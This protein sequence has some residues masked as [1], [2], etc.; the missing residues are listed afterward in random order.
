[1]CPSLMAV[2]SWTGLNSGG[3]QL[4]FF[5]PSWIYAEFNWNSQPSWGLQITIARASWSPLDYPYRNRTSHGAEFRWTNIEYYCQKYIL[6]FEFSPEYKPQKVVFA[7]RVIVGGT[8]VIY[9]PELML[10][11][12]EFR[13]IY[14]DSNGILSPYGD[15]R[16]QLSE[17]DSVWA[18]LRVME[19]DSWGEIPVNSHW[20][21]PKLDIQF[22]FSAE[23]EP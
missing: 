8:I 6:T 20:I 15:L 13:W 22:E 23:F 9:R 19:L 18:S 16:Q 14:S 11:S 17:L 2:L 4:N 10:N 7:G 12:V 21:P 1:M 3:I 5:G